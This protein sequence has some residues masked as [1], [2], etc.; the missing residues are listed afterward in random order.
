MALFDPSESSRL[1]I[2]LSALQGPVLAFVLRGV[3]KAERGDPI[4]EGR[5]EHFVY[6]LVGYVVGMFV[7]AGISKEHIVALLL[8]AIRIVS[9]DEPRS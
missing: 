7:E 2:A 4:V 5:I 1:Q 8:D 9:S 3:D 6:G